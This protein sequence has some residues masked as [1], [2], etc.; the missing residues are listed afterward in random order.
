MHKHPTPVHTSRLALLVLAALATLGL[1]LATSS[2]AGALGSD[3]IAQAAAKHHKKH[4]KHKKKRAR[5]ASAVSPVSGIYDSCSYGQSDGDMLPDCGDRLM[6]LHLA[7]FQVVL[8]YR[9]ADMST[10][11]A[12]RYADD[13][14]SLGMKVIWN[15]SAYHNL[16]TGQAVPVDSKLDLVR[17]TMDHP[18]TWGYYIGDEHPEDLP[19]ITEL[20]KA[21]RNIT[22]RPLLYLSRPN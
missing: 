15:L 3:A 14:A 9:T 8:N 6:A 12:L 1:M 10:E 5:K 19:Q 11:D 16:N 18:G 13:A 4:K 17:A 20:S 22:N 7:G 21:V 2:V